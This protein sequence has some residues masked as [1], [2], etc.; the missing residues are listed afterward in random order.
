MSFIKT[1][2][3]VSSQDSRVVVGR[4]DSGSDVAILGL[5]GMKQHLASGII[6]LRFSF[7]WFLGLAPK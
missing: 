1:L 3:L 5:E 6:L 4:P 7:D 2:L